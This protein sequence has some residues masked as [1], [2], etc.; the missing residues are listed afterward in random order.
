MSYTD[1][2]FQAAWSRALSLRQAIEHT[3]RDLQSLRQNP[4]SRSARSGLEEDATVIAEIA[5]ET[6]EALEALIGATEG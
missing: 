6:V 2:D 4:G 5:V 3:I 1:A